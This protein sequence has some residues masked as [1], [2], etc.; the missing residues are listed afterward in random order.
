[1]IKSKRT[2]YGIEMKRKAVTKNL[3]QKEYGVAVFANN[4]NIPEGT[5]R[6]WIKS[7][8]NNSASIQLQSEQRFKLLLEYLELDEKGKGLLLRKH[9]IYS[10]QI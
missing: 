8:I 6:G 1:M 10:H 7:P 4:E 2:Y 5:F 3:S 9:G